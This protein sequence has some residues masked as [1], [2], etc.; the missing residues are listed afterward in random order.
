MLGTIALCL[1]LVKFLAILFLLGN[2]TVEF[3]FT[4]S[5]SELEHGENNFEVLS[6]FLDIG[7]ERKAN[8]S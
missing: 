4:G 6:F 3:G 7:V 2:Q 5:K 8:V 1:S